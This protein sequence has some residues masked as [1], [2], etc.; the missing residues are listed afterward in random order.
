MFKIYEVIEWFENLRDELE[1]YHNADIV[2]EFIGI[3]DGYDAT[4]EKALDWVRFTIKLLEPVFPCFMASMIIG[5]GCSYLSI[6]L[7]AF[8]F[9]RV[10]LKTLAN[11]TED[12]I[13]KRM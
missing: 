6:S 3:L 12:V 1:K 11:P 9:K 5:A 10:V 8:H 7:T 2:F 13:Q 4:A